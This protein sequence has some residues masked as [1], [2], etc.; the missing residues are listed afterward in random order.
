MRKSVF[1]ALIG[2]SLGGSAAL[3][4]GGAGSAYG[5]CRDEITTG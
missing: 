3:A 1:A 4:N 2:A 5:Y